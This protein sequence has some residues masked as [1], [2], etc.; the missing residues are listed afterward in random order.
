MLSQVTKCKAQTQATNREEKVNAKQF[1]LIIL[2][3]HLILSHYL[4]YKLY[5]RLLQG[6][7]N[8]ACDT[9]GATANGAF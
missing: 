1:K 5:N 3:L 6:L 8:F 7:S 4:C 2:N 9:R